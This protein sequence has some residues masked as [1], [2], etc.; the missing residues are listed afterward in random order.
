MARKTLELDTKYAG[1]H[2]LLSLSY[3]GKEMFDEAIAENQRWGVLTG[4]KV[5]TTVAHAQLYALSGQEEQAKGI[6][7]RIETE[8]LLNENSYRGLALVHA[9]LGENDA[10]FQLLEKSYERREEWLLKL[11]S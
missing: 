10:A 7:K 8:K 11:E 6:V 5:E 2:R 9:A 4:N 3:Q 1:A